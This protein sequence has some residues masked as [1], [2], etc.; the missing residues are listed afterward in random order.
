[1]RNKNIEILRTGLMAV[2][3]SSILN[4]CT[5]VT[6]AGAVVGTAVGVTKVAVKGTVAVVDAA[7]PDADPEDKHEP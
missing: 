3:I 6:V 7:I 1:V 4:G 2:L 5:V